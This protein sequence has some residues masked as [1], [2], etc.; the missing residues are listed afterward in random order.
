MYSRQR[1]HDDLAGDGVGAVIVERHPLSALVT[2]A[3]GF[4][5]LLLT[6]ALVWNE[7]VP[8][9]EADLFDAVNGLPDGARFGLWPVMQLG[10][11]A[12][13]VI[14]P[15]L[16]LAVLRQ[17]R[18]AA[19]AASAGF[20]AWVLAKVVKEIVQRGRPPLYLDGVEVREGDGSGL[21]FVSGHGAVVGALVTALW[22]YL[23][24]PLR[25]VA[26]VLVALVGVGRVFYGAHLPLDMIGGYGLGVACGAL[27]G[28]V[29]GVTSPGE[30]VTE[31][32][33]GRLGLDPGAS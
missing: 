4:A 20:A 22:P 12:S 32:T 27:A 25:V 21:G 7:R 24:R 5:V 28:L 23:T 10:M 19:A 2:A 6:S 31:Q 15:A 9:W 3:V 18:P 13:V 16:A 11:I 1:L 8:S 30:H 29:T 14:V 17:W 33:G 26:I